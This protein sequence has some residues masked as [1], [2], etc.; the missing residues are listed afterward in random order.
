MTSIGSRQTHVVLEANAE[1]VKY[2]PSGHL[3]FLDAGKL[4][5]APFDVASMAITGPPSTM[6]EDV[7]T[8]AFSSSGLLVF[9]RTD[10]VA[11]GAE[12]CTVVWVDRNGREDVLLA[13]P[14]G[15]LHPRL[16][17][18]G[19]R[20]LIQVIKG[21]GSQLVGPRPGEGPREAIHVRRRER[22]A[23]VD[24]R[25]ARCRCTRRIAPGPSGTFSRHLR[26]VPGA[27]SIVL[28]RPLTQFPATVSPDGSQIV[29]GETDPNRGDTLW[30]YRCAEAP[31]RNRSSITPRAR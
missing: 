30:T 4:I 27:P 8:F 19:T 15:Y 21:Y 26:T 14:Q 23:A 3:L 10:S 2:A 5:A 24:A 29:F 11:S 13:Q 28:G 25:R 9:G 18:D 31:T 16:S 20:L 1:R 12:L 22:M 7:G 6:L 17:P